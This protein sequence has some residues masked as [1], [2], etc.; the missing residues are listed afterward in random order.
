MKKL[1]SILL[2]AAMLVTFP[3]SV[4]NSANNSAN[5]SAASAHT[6]TI[7]DVL[8]ILKDLASLE[9]LTDEQVKLYDF[10]G[11]GEITI[12]NALE[13]LKYLAGL[14]NVIS[15]A[16]GQLIK[17]GSHDWRVLDIQDGKALI[18]TEN[19]VEDMIQGFVTTWEQGDIRRWLNG[20]FYNRFSA[21]E[22]SRINL[23][24]VTNPGNPQSGEY[25]G[26]DTNDYVFLLS[27]EEV[28]KYFADNS[29]FIKLLPG[30]EFIFIK[31]KYSIF[32]ILMFSAIKSICIR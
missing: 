21:T 31:L 13:I 8:N 10:F 16:T 27:F 4:N 20:E 17:F 23:T 12:D 25:S 18:I 3:V 15:I 14:E 29:S 28:K 11:D 2:T 7:E 26:A 6:F 1:T 30:S 19:I 22:K 24:T 9:K 5:I 32:I